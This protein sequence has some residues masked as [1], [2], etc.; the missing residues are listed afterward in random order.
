MHVF[1]RRLRAAR[2]G[3]R[4]GALVMVAIVATVFAS[5]SLSLVTLNTTA[6]REQRVSREEVD[7]LYVAE[8][9]LA[10]AYSLVARGDPGER[11]TKGQQLS[12]GESSYWVDDVD[13]GGGRRALVS[14]AT[15][16]RSGARVRLVLE[17][18]T[19]T[20]WEWAAFGDERLTMDS[21]AHV[22]SYDSSAGSY[23]SQA[24]NGG[25]SDTYADDDG[26]VGSNG[27]I[28]LD[29]NS[30]VYG[31]AVPGAGEAVT[32]SGSATVT[33]STAPATE[34]VGFPPLVI[35]AFPSLGD[36]TVANN[37]TQHVT[38][39]DYRYEDFR[40][41]SGARLVVDGP[42]RLVFSNFEMRSGSELAVDATHGPVE[43]FVE[44]DFVM[45]SNT[46]I[47]STDFTP[48][49]IAINLL[50]DNVIDPNLHVDLDEVDFNSN[51]ELY[52]TVYAPNAAIEI[53]SNF[54]LYGSLVARTVH[55][56]SNS[57]IHFDR[58]LLDAGGVETEF[59]T[60]LWQVQP[61]NPPK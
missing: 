57:Y 37:S 17:E 3:R 53:N 61:Y 27:P 35:P 58:A 22:D 56:D 55:L 60:V 40:L 8:A 16:G 1:E 25:G 12:F 33:G 29:Q 26:D 14:T 18:V 23:S 13:L 5:I 43:I 7:A 28:A 39:G 49:D 24:V 30:T 4:G 54:E 48:A 44:N 11:G 36:L 6:L 41:G 9:G 45:N 32:L 46:L 34:S 50:S 19:T 2:P 21:N 51:A 47:A 59:R 10:D 31:S 20:F 52:G 42:A 38:A 15:V